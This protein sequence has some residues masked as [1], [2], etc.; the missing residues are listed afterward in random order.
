MNIFFLQKQNMSGVAHLHVSCISTGFISSLGLD[1]LTALYEAIVKDFN[2]FCLVA[3]DQGKVLGFVAFTENLGRLYKSAVK[4]NGIKLILAI[5]LKMFHPSVCQRII[6][7]I[8][9]P[10]KTD[11]MDLPKA[12]LLSI[13]VDPAFQ[14]KGIAKQLCQA[15]LVQC[16]KRGID[17][18]KVLVAA[19]NEPA[20]RLY[21]KC[22]F[23]L[24]IQVDSHSIPSNI[25]VADLTTLINV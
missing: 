8:F 15:G 24:V 11:K 7:N 25:Y 5:G 20:N 18:V 19:N 4:S 3:E 21:I 10:S 6:Q 23:E 1:F 16:R 12:E 9:Y 13:V 14:G 17:K 22:G 2:S